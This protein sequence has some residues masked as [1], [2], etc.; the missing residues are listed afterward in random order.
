M[1]CGTFL[2]KEV[3]IV[4]MVSFI[5]IKDL[6]VF[7]F[8]YKS[9]LE[10]I[11]IKHKI[12]A[13]DISCIYFSFFVLVT[14]ILSKQK[15]VQTNIQVSFPS[16]EHRTIIPSLLGSKQSHVTVLAKKIWTEV[17][18][19]SGKANMFLPF[20]SPALAIIEKT[21]CWNHRKAVLKQP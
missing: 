11:L 4:H 5:N 15:V 6:F 12:R 2:L 13:Q 16:W 3:R 14:T 8:C 10:K 1:I 9:N 21:V 17:M 7:I 19:D 18:C 20:S